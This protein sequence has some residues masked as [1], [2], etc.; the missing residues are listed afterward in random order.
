M[1]LITWK[2]GSN[3]SFTYRLEHRK[4]KATPSSNLDLFHQGNGTQKLFAWMSTNGYRFASTMTNNLWT[5][6][7]TKYTVYILYGIILFLTAIIVYCLHT[8]CWSPS[9]IAMQ[10]PNRFSRPRGRPYS[11]FCLTAFKSRPGSGMTNGSGLGHPKVISSFVPNITSRT[12]MIH[13]H[14]SWWSHDPS[15]ATTGLPTPRLINRMQYT[16]PG[17]VIRNHLCDL[18]CLSCEIAGLVLFSKN[19]WWFGPA[20]SM[21]V[22]LAK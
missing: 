4:T 5:W 6:T 2:L 7:S 3:S 15:A 19:Y 17:R 20:W 14:L 1:H 9:N 22:A 11:T 8:G 13:N 12:S 18:G 21:K 16:F 10:V